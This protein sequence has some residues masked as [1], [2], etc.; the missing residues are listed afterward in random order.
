MNAILNFHYS[1]DDPIFKEYIEIV[2]H[3]YNI[4]SV[5]K[6]LKLKYNL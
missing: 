1:K 2:L 3:S 6:K 4:E 5:I